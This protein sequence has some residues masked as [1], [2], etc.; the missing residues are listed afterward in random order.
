MH[1]SMST[2]VHPRPG[3][4]EAFGGEFSVIW[5]ACVASVSPRVRRERRDESKKNE[6]TF[7][8]WLDW[9]RL[10]RRLLFDKQNRGRL[11]HTKNS[12]GVDRGVFHRGGLGGQFTFSINS[13]AMKQFF[14]VCFSNLIYIFKL[15]LLT[16]N[17]LLLAFGILYFSEILTVVSPTPTRVEHQN[18][19]NSPKM[20][21]NGLRR[22]R[23]QRIQQ[24][25]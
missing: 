21:Q 1:Q 10:L 7:A 17:P 23:Q 8:Q 16:I 19:A 15:I 4:I 20:L 13:S 5:L 14:F 6:W 3:H 24:S 25:N 12:G 9:K 2:P 18:S 22:G 11:L